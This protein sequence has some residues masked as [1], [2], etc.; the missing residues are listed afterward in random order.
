MSYS[1]YFP[2]SFNIFKYYAFCC[3]SV[4]FLFSSLVFLFF[5]S[6]RSSLPLLLP[7]YFYYCMHWF[8]FFIPSFHYLW[9]FVFSSLLPFSPPF[10][11]S[12]GS[13][14]PFP[15]SVFS[16]RL[17]FFFFVLLLSSF[18]MHFY[19][20]PPFSFFVEVEGDKNIIHK[21]NHEN[22]D[23]LNNIIN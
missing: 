21:E 5:Y 20:F 8:S 22:T 14:Y 12:L 17:Y 23:F 9:S 4:T 18:L 16:F 19:S 7:S 2:S 1:F 15:P 13:P 6:Y 10:L 11:Y 3:S